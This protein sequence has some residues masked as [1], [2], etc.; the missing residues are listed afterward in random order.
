MCLGRTERN[1]TQVS[2]RLG[3]GI[4]QKTHRINH[5]YVPLC[6]PFVGRASASRRD[7]ATVDRRI[8]R[9]DARQP[10]PPTKE[11]SEV[12][13]MIKR[14][15]ENALQFL[16]LVLAGT[17]QPA[18]AQSVPAPS[19]SPLKVWSAEGGSLGSAIKGFYASTGTTYSGAVRGP[20]GGNT[21]AFASQIAGNVWFGG[22]L[23]EKLGLRQ[24][25]DIWVRVYQFFPETFCFSY[26]GLGDG[27]GA[28]KWMRAQTSSGRSTLELGSASPNYDGTYA[29]KRTPACGTVTAAYGDINEMGAGNRP[30]PNYTAAP[31]VRGKWQALQV[32]WHFGDSDG[33]M[34]AWID[35]VYLGQS[36]HTTLRSGA[37]VEG[38]VYGDYWNGGFPV[39]QGFHY[40]EIVITTERP[41]TVDS[42]GRPFIHP[43]HRVADFSG[44][45]APS[46]PAPPQG[47]SVQ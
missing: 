29:F 10:T 45:G 32:H 28:T 42:G 21:T 27:W 6:Q 19:Y 23:V 35:D 25:S 41:N 2:C 3:S 18:A 37:V 38:I 22:N 46:R 40:D 4:L 5:L 16:V 20:F 9:P 14:I 17:I 44:S 11:T 1:V 13:R 24:G 12:C 43:N 34:R 8:I 26:G 30:F 31:I 7:P 47:L 36:N 39:A 15:R 33:Y